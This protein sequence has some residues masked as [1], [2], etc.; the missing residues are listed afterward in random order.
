M[1]EQSLEL[2]ILRKLNISQEV[3]YCHLNIQTGLN[4]ARNNKTSAHLHAR[5]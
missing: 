4:D 3:S 5:H 2:A 1:N